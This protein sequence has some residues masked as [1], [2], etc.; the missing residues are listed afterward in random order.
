MGQQV[1]PPGLETRPARRFLRRVA[2][3]LASVAEWLQ[4]SPDRGNLLGAMSAGH[5]DRLA[6]LNG[7]A[8]SRQRLASVTL[9]IELD[10]V[11]RTDLAGG[12]QIVNPDGAYLKCVSS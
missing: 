3:G 9:D 11:R 6:C 1:I 10:D 12:H 2:G 5:Y 8:C 7:V 4:D